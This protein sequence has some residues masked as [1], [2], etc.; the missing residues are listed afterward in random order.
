MGYK[1]EF[2]TLL[3]ISMSMLITMPC[4]CNCFLRFSDFLIS[5]MK[6]QIFY[7]GLTNANDHFFCRKEKKNYKCIFQW[8]EDLLNVKNQFFTL[9]ICLQTNADCK[10]V[11]NAEENVLRLHLSFHRIL[12]SVFQ[13]A[14]VSLCL[15]H[16]EQPKKTFTLG[17]AA[18]YF[19]GR[20]GGSK[21]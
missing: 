11:K 10:L 9:N 3:L 4:C 1:S 19:F 8:N 20:E 15:S 2:A 7:G 16:V 18:F 17:N 13:A 6:K 12:H 21:T 5:L 14:T